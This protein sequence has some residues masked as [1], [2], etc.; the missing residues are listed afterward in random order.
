VCKSGCSI[1]IDNYCLQVTS[2]SP[3]LS[4]SCSLTLYS[5]PLSLHSPLSLS[6]SLTFLLYFTYHRFYLSL[7]PQICE[8]QPRDSFV[9]IT[10]LTR[11][12]T[13]DPLPVKSIISSNIFNPRARERESERPR[14]RETERARELES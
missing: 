12:I 6:L 11:L 3:S 2:L 7:F 1:A 4:P 14:D 5:L 10:S 8:T 13:E 9:T